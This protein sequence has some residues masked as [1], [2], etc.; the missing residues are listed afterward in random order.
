MSDLH[1]S[2]SQ[3]LGLQV[4]TPVPCC[5]SL[6]DMVEMF[7]CRLHKQVLSQPSYM[8]G[9]EMFRIQVP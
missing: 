8:L 2:T 9:V 1:E 7:Y 6:L 4:C 5:V 3:M